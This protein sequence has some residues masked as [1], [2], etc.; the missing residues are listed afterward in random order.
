[1]TND[2]TC[3]R[4][5]MKTDTDY[6]SC[7]YDLEADYD[8]LPSNISLPDNN[9]ISKILSR[10]LPVTRKCFFKL[11]TDRSFDI[12]VF[13]FSSNFT[14][15]TEK[16]QDD[17]TV[18]KLINVN[19]CTITDNNITGTLKD[20]S[21]AETPLLS[22][23]LLSMLKYTGSENLTIEVYNQ[24]GELITTITKPKKDLLE[25]IN[26][27]DIN[28]EKAYLKFKFKQHQYLTKITT[29]IKEEQLITT[30]NNRQTTKKG[31]PNITTKYSI[32]ING[33]KIKTHNNTHDIR[34]QKYQTSTNISTQYTILLNNTIMKTK[35]P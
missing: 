23:H 8:D 11:S 10:T 25:N 6:N 24:N 7:V 29:Y 14:V 31:K 13:S 18:N 19:N 35:H 1:M 16:V 21:T 17:I 4:K 2:V 5:Y 26:T 33:N 27:S 34:K 30:I 3:D 9:D 20:N 28:T 12:G 32:L 22:I 15:F